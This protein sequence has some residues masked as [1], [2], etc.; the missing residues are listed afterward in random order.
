MN[1]NGLAAAREAYLTAVRVMGPTDAVRSIVAAY[2]AADE[3]APILKRD[4]SRVSPTSRALAALAVGDKVTLANTAPVLVRHLCPTARALMG[5]ND[6]TWRMRALPCGGVEATRLADGQDPNAKDPTRNA[7]AVELASLAV[8]QFK[9][10]VHIKSVRGAGSVNQSDKTAARKILGNPQAD[11]KT[12]T[13]NRGVRILRTHDR[14]IG[15]PW[16]RD[17]EVIIQMVARQYNV[18][19]SSMLGHA[20]GRASDARIDAW[21]KLFNTGLWGNKKIGE[22][23][24]RTGN[25]VA[26]SRSYAA[27]SKAPT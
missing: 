6:A 12:E 13:L 14:I 11:W 4:D 5:N 8:G 26:V 19:V 18:A 7:K 23:F 1:P 25:C 15:P 24:G 9:T 3:P 27:K 17:A 21:E 2:L 10:G 16:P 22:W 20:R